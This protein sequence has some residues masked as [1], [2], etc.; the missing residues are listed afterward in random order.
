LRR[1]FSDRVDVVLLNP[2]AGIPVFL[3]V[4]WLLFELTTRFAAPLQGAIGQL[5]NVPMAAGVTWLLSLMGLGDNWVQGLL[6]DGLLVGVGTVLTFLPVMAVMFTAL[7][8]LED[9][10]YLARAAFVADRAM[11][12]LGLDGRALLPLIVGFGCNL[13]ALA[14]TRTLPHARQRL[15][16]GLLIPLTSCSARL[17]VYVLLA[18]AFFPQHAGTVIFAMYLTSVLLVL[19]GG[20]VLRRTAFRDVR[21]GPLMLVLPPYQRPHLRTLAMSVRLRVGSFVVRAGKIIVVT[22]LV[23]WVLMAVPVTGQHSVGH[24]PVADSLYYSVA[25][26]IAPLLTPTGFGNDH[27][28]AALMTGFVAKEVVVGSFAQSYAVAEPGSPARAGGLGEQLRRS[29][30]ESSGGRGGAAALA[31]MV[32][33]LAYTP[34]AAALAEQRRLFGWRTAASALTAQLAGAWVLAVLVFQVG[35]RL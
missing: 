9:S 25:S 17:T 16:T 8:F 7:G 35:S 2:W 22:M 26:G 27:A 33:V 30:D 1:T 18:G 4:V 15:L 29:F 19:G 23:V 11:R 24:V 6:V 32:F 20:L 13:P 28:S 12:S 3:A 10:G 14:A 21:A 34:C 5:V 31:F